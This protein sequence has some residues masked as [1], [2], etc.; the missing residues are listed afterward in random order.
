MLFMLRLDRTVPEVGA[1]LSP[2]QNPTTSSMP[3]LE[4]SDVGSA[5]INP[6]GRPPLGE[7]RNTDSASPPQPFPVR[8]TRSFSKTLNRQKTPIPSPEKRHFEAG[9]GPTFAKRR[10]T[11]TPESDSGKSRTKN[12]SFKSKLSP[13]AA[14]RTLGKSPIN[15]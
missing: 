11:E 2:R 10:R 14:A 1:L 4:H 12:E 13:S 8:M 7:G 9:M 5:K 15:Y 6:R 3:V